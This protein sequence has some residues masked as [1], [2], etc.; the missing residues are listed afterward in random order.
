MGGLLLYMWESGC[1]L[2]QVILGT[3]QGILGIQQSILGTQQVILGTQQAFQ[4]TQQ[5]IL[6]TK[7]YIRLFWVPLH[8]EDRRRYVPYLSSVLF[9]CNK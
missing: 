7:Q 3:Q 2:V 1:T 4:G 8:R 9:V 5:V 6:G